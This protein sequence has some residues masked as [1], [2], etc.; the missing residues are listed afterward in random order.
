MLWSKSMAEASCAEAD[1]CAV[2]EES[3]AADCVVWLLP[4]SV[5]AT[6]VDDGCVELGFRFAE[7][8]AG[9]EA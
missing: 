7:E 2:E 8:A 6:A 9:S 5:W 3:D 1:G 4:E